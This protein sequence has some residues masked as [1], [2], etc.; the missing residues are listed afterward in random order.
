MY[1]VTVEFTI[2][3]QQFDRFLPLMTENAHR[4]REDEPGCQQFDVCV[5]DAR[6]GVV[7]LYEIYDDRAAFDAHLASPHFRSFA[8]ATQAMITERA[9]R[10]WRRVAP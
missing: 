7:H 1:V 2:D 9:I 4:S 6:P 8:A 5:D 3:P 10:T